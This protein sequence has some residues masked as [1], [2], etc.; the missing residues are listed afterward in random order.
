MQDFLVVGSTAREGNGKNRVMSLLSLR[1]K[2]KLTG[3]L[4]YNLKKKRKICEY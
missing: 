1:K 2:P 4:K 3:K